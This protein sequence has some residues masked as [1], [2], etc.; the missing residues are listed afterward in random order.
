MSSDSTLTGSSGY[1][2]QGIN[3]QG[4]SVNKDH[5]EVNLDWVDPVTKQY[6]DPTT[7]TVTVTKDGAAYSPSKV[8]VQLSRVD[9]TVGVWH[10]SFLTTDMV[11]GAYV[12]TFS[13]S[14]ATIGPVTH[15]LGFTSAEIPVEQY[16]IGVLRAR[17]ADKR[18]SRY[19]IDD[20]M[21]VRFSDGELYSYLDDAR[22]RVGQEPPQPVLLPWNQAYA[23][24]HDLIVTGGFVGALEARGIL[25]TFNKFNYS[26]ELSLNIDRSSF[27]QN[28]QSLRSQWLLSIK[29]WKRDHI[30]HIVRSIGMASGKYPQYY[31][32]VL[33]LLPH[34]SRIYYG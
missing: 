2:I 8:L 29:T 11:A 16:F 28:A 33:S 3:T 30:F 22:L 13:G 32:R 7:A 26:D 34:M 31:T 4:I 6:F 23:E 14:T 15:V 27:F 17:L 5:V 25:E 12:F 10:Y 24:T 1:Q 18:A 20:N 9:D 19:L 21:R